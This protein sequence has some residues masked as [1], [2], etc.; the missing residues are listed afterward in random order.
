MTKNHHCLAPAHCFN[1]ATVMIGFGS[2]GKGTLP[3]F[4]QHIIFDRKKF[5]V[6]APEDEDRHLLDDR[7]L[8]RGGDAGAPP[9]AM[10]SF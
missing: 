9:T 1:G 7:K 10:I 2:I 5:V 6:F 3:L 4:E 8:R